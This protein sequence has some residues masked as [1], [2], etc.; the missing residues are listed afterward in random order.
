M[1]FPEDIMC[2]QIVE[3]ISDYVEGAMSAEER[4]QVELHLNLCDG[5]TDY[6]Q[7]MRLAIA[8][9]GRIEPELL[10]PELEAELVEAFRG[11]RR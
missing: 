8:L 6:L 4:E 11:L 3:L 10:P 7:Q 2:K 1:R 5:C 9:S